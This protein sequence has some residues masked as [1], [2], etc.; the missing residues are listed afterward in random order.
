MAMTGLTVW[1]IGIGA[2]VAGL[3]VARYGFSRSQLDAFRAALADRD[4]RL[5]EFRA[6]YEQRAEELNALKTEICRVSGRASRAADG[7]IEVTA[8]DSFQ[9]E[10]H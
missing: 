6:A 8:D 9:P 1:F 2:F 5:D 4:T 7:I 10:H 3:A